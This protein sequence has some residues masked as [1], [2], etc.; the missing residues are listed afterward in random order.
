ML[1]RV[2]KRGDLIDNITGGITKIMKMFGKCQNIIL[3]QESVTFFSTSSNT[4]CNF[5]VGWNVEDFVLLKQYFASEKM[6][7]ISYFYEL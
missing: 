6:I 5:I 1:N 7:N 4:L 3:V 2:L